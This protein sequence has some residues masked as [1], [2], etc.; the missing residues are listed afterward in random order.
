[1]C[2]EVFGMTMP[3]DEYKDIELQIEHEYAQ[4]INL[5]KII[6]FFIKITISKIFKRNS[7]KSK[8]ENVKIEI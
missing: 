4:S 3:A 1:M 8:L 5:H 2:G 7:K 6:L